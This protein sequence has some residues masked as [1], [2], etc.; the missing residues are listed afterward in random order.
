VCGFRGEQ[1]VD[2]N[3]EF[4][5]QDARELRKNMK[6]KDWFYIR[7]SDGSFSYSQL[8]EILEVPPGP[9]RRYMITENNKLKCI[10][11]KYELK[12][13]VDT[14]PP[15]NRVVGQIARCI[16]KEICIPFNKKTK[17][18]CQR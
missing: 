9:G 4:S 1:N 12:F 15:T 11:Y 10:E 6:R 3:D 2:Y 7:H 17:E 18:F 13:Q 8:V 14:L 5:E 16:S